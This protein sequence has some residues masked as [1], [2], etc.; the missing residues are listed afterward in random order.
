MQFAS[1]VTDKLHLPPNCNTDCS[2]NPNLRSCTAPELCGPRTYEQ[3]LRV[4]RNRLSATYTGTGV[5]FVSADSTPSSGAY[6]QLNDDG[7][8]NGIVQFIGPN[9]YKLVNKPVYIIPPSNPV[10]SKIISTGE[11]GPLFTITT[12]S[13]SCCSC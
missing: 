11:S 3:R 7:N 5:S 10:S 2:G 8:P 4:Q 1:D 12:T 9:T 13:S 6:I